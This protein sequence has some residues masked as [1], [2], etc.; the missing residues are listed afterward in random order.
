MGQFI[1]LRINCREIDRLRKTSAGYSV[2]CLPPL[3][4]VSKSINSGGSL[5]LPKLAQAPQGPAP[6]PHANAPTSS[7]LGLS[8]Q[9]LDLRHGESVL[10]YMIC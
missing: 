9:I 10:R 5:R 3:L 7:K 6:A 4:A 2:Y 1:S 8:R